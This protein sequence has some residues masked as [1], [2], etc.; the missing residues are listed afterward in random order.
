MTVE[1]IRVDGTREQHE[2]TA[3]VAAIAIIQRAIGATCL[4][5]VNLRDG[6]VMLVDD[7]GARDGKPANEEATRLYVGVCRP[8][9]HPLPVHGDVA[10]AVDSDFA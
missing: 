5:V 8:G 6:R 10:I 2:I 4:D 3:H 1:I 9:S 7:T